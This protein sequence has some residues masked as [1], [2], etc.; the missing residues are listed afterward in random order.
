MKIFIT[1]FLRSICLNSS[2][3][4]GVSSSPSTAFGLLV[5]RSRSLRLRGTANVFFPLSWMTSF[6]G[7]L[8]EDDFATGGSEE[9][10]PSCFASPSDGIF[11]PAA[12]SILAKPKKEIILAFAGFDSSVNR[13]SSLNHSQEV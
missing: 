11:G 13:H 5:F 1:Y 7:P 3:D 9:C 4:F 6:L 8:L 2:L 12:Q 10:F